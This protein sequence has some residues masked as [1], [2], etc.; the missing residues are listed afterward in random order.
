VRS[1][2]LISFRMVSDGQHRVPGDLHPEKDQMTGPYVQAAV[3]LLCCLTVLS[4]SR[5]YALGS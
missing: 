1:S 5:F 3:S 2:C 4:K